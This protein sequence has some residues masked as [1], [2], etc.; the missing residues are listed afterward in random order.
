MVESNL[1][2]IRCSVAGCAG[3]AEV[4][5]MY[6]V[7]SVADH[8][9]RWCISIF[10]LGFVAGLALGFLG[11]GVG[12]SEGKTRVSVVERGFVD[13]RDVLI[14]SFM[15]RMAFATFLLL[16]QLAMIVLLAFYILADVFMTVLAQLRLRRLIEPLVAF[17]AGLLPFRVPLN[18]LA[19]H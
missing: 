8:A 19:R 14:S 15:L 10:D 6:V 12:P 18:D 3:R 16:F 4:T 1:F 9:F 13:R 2:P 17:G 11:V 7:F 5:F